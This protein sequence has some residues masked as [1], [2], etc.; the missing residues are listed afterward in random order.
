M[1][2]Q[3]G[4]TAALGFCVLSVMPRFVGADEWPQINGA[5]QTRTAHE[6][7][8]LAMSPEV[9][10][11]VPTDT[12]FSSFVVGNG[13]AFTVVRRTVG[14]ADREVCVAL[15]FSDGQE[16]WA[17]PLGPA[18]YDGGGDAGVWDNRG[19]DG[20]R[21]TPAINEGKV[22]V[23]DAQLGLHCL[24]ADSGEV[25]WS[26][27]IIDGYHGQ[28]IRWQNGASP[29]VDGDLVFVAGG[30]EGESLLA[31]NKDT[32]ELAWKAHDEKLTHAT[33]VA[34]TI[35]G[36]RQVIFV[37]Q[38][39]LLAVEP[40]TGK[41]LWRQPYEYRTASGASPVVYGDIVYY[42]A[43]YSV[44]A[45]A[46][47]VTRTGE[48]FSVSEIWRKKNE[49]MNT[50]STPACKDGNLYGHYGHKKY[51]KSPLQ[52]VELATGEIRWSQKGFGPGNCIVV[53]DHVA[54]LSD[55]GEVVIVEAKP[56]EYK[57]VYREDIL[58]GKCWSSPA[59]AT[60][61]LFVRSTIEGACIQMTQ[62]D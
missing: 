17:R 10:W 25:V 56:E 46:Y 44:G 61:R 32:G 47:R 36:V 14:K 4:R 27:D 30:G 33:P 34:A 20:P 6:Q 37:V 11:S 51:G 16:M 38:S 50:W 43:G 26:T 52:C 1:K 59:F 48:E 5:D 23:L 53:G 39:G 40:T 31:F 3:I 62:V 58:S 45:G 15:D 18:K 19:G 41:I 24:V 60:G 28:K 35:H 42:S 57:E 55:A 54:A 29:L 49:L 13:K 2:R 7:I 22:Y 8:D 9:V 12:G 21:S